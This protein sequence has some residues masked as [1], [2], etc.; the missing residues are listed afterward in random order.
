MSTVSYEAS[1]EPSEAIHEEK[2]AADKGDGV[3]VA[4]LRDEKASDSAS[5]ASSQIFPAN[6]TPEQ[7]RKRHVHFITLCACFILEGW[8]DGSLGPLL[9]RIQQTFHVGHR[10]SKNLFQK[11]DHMHILRS[12]LR[13]YHFYSCLYPL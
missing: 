10:P 5:V 2:V 12:I 4:V 11:I 7:N 13:L 9:P 8:H 1:S 6:P 3:A